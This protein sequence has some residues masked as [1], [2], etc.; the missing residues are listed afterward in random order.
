MQTSLILSVIS[1]KTSVVS[2][3]S[4]SKEPEDAGQVSG[5]CS[6]QTAEVH[7]SCMSGEDSCH[8]GLPMLLFTQHICKHEHVAKAEYHVTIFSGLFV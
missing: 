7:G 5:N 4:R 2:G 1:L 8:V 6:G 3:Q